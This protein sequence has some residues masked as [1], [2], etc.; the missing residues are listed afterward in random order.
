M[1][2]IRKIRKNGIRKNVKSRPI[3]ERTVF[4]FR[5][6]F[7][8]KDRLISKERY[9]DKRPAPLLYWLEINACDENTLKEE[10]SFM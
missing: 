3:F 2:K 4:F 9:S 8:K 6:E 5:N 1:Y 7:R 10:N